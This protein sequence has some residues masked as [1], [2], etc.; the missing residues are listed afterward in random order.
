MIQSMEELEA[1]ALRLP[2]HERALL[3]E[4]LISSLD[5]EDEEIERAW[6][7]EAQRRYLRYKAGEG[8][9]R[10]LEDVLADIEARRRR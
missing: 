6:A 8:T 2:K 5:E 7:E 9:A 1:G 10:P 3:A 4:R